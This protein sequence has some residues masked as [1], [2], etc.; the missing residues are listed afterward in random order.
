MQMA[1][2]H[3]C[4]CVGNCLS[5][6]KQHIICHQTLCGE[7]TFGKLTTQ[8]CV[9]IRYVNLEGQALDPVSP[10]S[11]LAVELQVGSHCRRGWP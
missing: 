5:P 3:G 7:L 8:D 11:G 4:V 1:V 9:P 2:L 6:R 10:L